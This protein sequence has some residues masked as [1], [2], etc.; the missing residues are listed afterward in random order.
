M[1]KHRILL[2]LLI[3]SIA[4]SSALAQEYDPAQ[5]DFE[6]RELSDDEVELQFQLALRDGWRIYSQHSDQNGPTPMRFFFSENTSYTLLGNVV[7][8][9]AEKD[10]D[11]IFGITLLYF[12]NKVIF[13]QRIRR[14][15]PN[16][17]NVKG[18][19]DYQFVYKGR[20]IPPDQIRFVFSVPA[21][22]NRIVANVVDR[23]NPSS[24]GNTTFRN[25]ATNKP[26]LPK[27]DTDKDIP[28][29]GKADNKT[30]AFVIAN[31]NY[32]GRQVPYALNDGQIFATYCNRTLG[33]PQNHIKIF[34]NA[35]AGQIMACVASI[36]KASEAND[37]DINI[38]FY[39]A[40]HA[41]PDEN[42]KDAYLLPVDGDSR[43]VETCYSLKR[44]YDELGKIK[45]HQVVCF[46]DACFSGA[47][48]E[49]DM[50][51]TGRGVA[52][53][54]KEETPQGNLIVFTSASGNE[55]AHQ[56]EEKQHGLFT[57]YL[58]KKMQDSKGTF[59]LGEMY[60]YVSKNVKKTSFDV[61]NKI[62]TP[63]VIP[64]ETMGT[65]WRNIKL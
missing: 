17:F 38:I 23:Q 65:K 5:W 26:S 11:D 27:S 19:V 34:E 63:S 64:S 37:G 44:L 42:T 15:T 2:Y 10:Y 48:R 28:A 43:L 7:E 50:L 62:Q 20:T 57:Y 3:T 6:V 59:T 18:A 47:T 31:E 36:K 13:S 39:Y 16:A 1:V 49:D 60:D 58:L 21:A 29:T 51:L 52:I 9:K 40:G 54:P 4:C 33:I 32:P 12:T 30:Y 41:F 22:E 46:L 45:T 8:P 25:G 53:K 55:T 56:Y 24:Q 61:N 14:N 35:T